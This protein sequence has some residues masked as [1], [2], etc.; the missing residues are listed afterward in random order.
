MLSIFMGFVKHRVGMIVTIQERVK[1]KEPG[2][3][4]GK[5]STERKNKNHR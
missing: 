4:T 3:D 5:N 2:L 1:K